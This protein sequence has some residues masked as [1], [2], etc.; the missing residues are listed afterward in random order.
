MKAGDKPD[1]RNVMTVSSQ[2]WLE[3][4][5]AVLIDGGNSASRGPRIFKPYP[6]Y[7]AGASGA[8]LTDVEGHDYIDWMMAFGALPLG[9]AHPAVV[10]AASAAI[11]KGS[12]LA[13][14]TPVEVELAELI[15]QL[16]P[17]AEKVRFASTGT[18]AVMA[19]VR[20][21][22]GYTGRRKILKF[23][24]HYNGWADGVL[25]TTNPQPI[26]TFVPLRWRA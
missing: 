2:G 13:A 21:A 7:M 8:R 16:V 6:P 11:A 25:V 19:A 17:T 26:A 5:Q 1:R 15:C 14:S 20:L 10:E 22:R 9:H 23:E 3:R 12:H 18:E 4:A 24:G